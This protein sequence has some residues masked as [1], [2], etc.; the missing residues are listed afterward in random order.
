[1]FATITL[2]FPPALPRPSRSL[3]CAALMAPVFGG[4]AEDVGAATPAAAEVSF[5]EAA[6]PTESDA[7]IAAFGLRAAPLA[8]AADTN[9][10]ILVDTSASQTGDFRRRALDALAGLLETARDGDRVRIAAVDIA[11]SS[12]SNDFASATDAATRDA[13]R[14]LDARTPLGSTDIVAVLEAAPALFSAAARSSTSAMALGSRA[15]SRLLLQP[16]STR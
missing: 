6:V 7:P 2:L 13:V 8:A 10:L 14:R 5:V 4:F 11:C 3:I 12:L 9:V 1:M 16:C 15:S